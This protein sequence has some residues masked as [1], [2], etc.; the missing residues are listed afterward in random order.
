M[1]LPIDISS[2]IPDDGNISETS[3]TPS[4]SQY[5]ANVVRG[6]LQEE[7]WFCSKEKEHG[8]LERVNSCLSFVSF[9][10]R[11]NFVV[12]SVRLECAPVTAMCSVNHQVWL[13]AEDGC[14]ILYDAI[15]HC[16]S[17][18]RYLSF[19]PDQ[20]IIHISHLTKLRQVRMVEMREGEKES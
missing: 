13:G 15:N 14:L 1:T 12:D 2:Q 9:R 17:Y 6:D 3:L 7:V 11:A 4:V 18:S 20:G 16:Q 8:R 5:H 19:K 10:G